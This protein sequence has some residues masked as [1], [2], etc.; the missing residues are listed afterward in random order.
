VWYAAHIVTVFRYR[1]PAKARR[2]RS[3]HVWENIVL[4]EADS[5][6]AAR[7]KAEEYGRADAAHDDPTWRFGG[8]PMRLE[9]V[10]V[11][12][13]VEC[14]VDRDRPGQP[15][16]G[17]EVTYNKFNLSSRADLDRFVNGDAVSVEYGPS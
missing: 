7:Q 9:Y 4:V 14:L 3:F 8:V 17:T 15:G 12:K 6:D 16:D 11:R 1:D 5:H 2:Q 10:G 13:T